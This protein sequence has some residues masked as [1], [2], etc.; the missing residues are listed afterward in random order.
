MN[1]NDE[2]GYRP[3][4][5]RKMFQN[6]SEDYD[7]LNHILT[8][9]LDHRWRKRAASLC[10]EDSPKTILDLCCGT[11]DLILTIREQGHDGTGAVG[12]D[13]TD[14]MIEKAC[15]RTGKSLRLVIA[16][17][18]RLPFMDNSFDC[19]ATA[20]SFRNLV[21]KNPGL[22]G[23][24]AEVLRILRQGGRFLILET[25]QPKQEIIRRIYHGYLRN[26]VPFIGGLVSGSRGAYTYL[27]RSALSFPASEDIAELLRKAGFREVAFKPLLLGIVGIH[28]A[29]K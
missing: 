7:L 15:L 27:G 6:V 17:A 14:A 4:S 9:G 28:I 13:F 23:Y 20:F 12:V 16:D 1:R 29:M 8:F 2:T 22:Q 11:G 19:V 24:L 21:Y 26:V 18:G 10:F 5:L 3:G 25:S